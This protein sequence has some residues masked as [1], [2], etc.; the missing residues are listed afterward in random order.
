M[1]IVLSSEGNGF[2]TSNTAYNT[3]MCT[4]MNAEDGLQEP[5]IVK[6]LYKELDVIGIRNVDCVKQQDITNEWI[7]DYVMLYRMDK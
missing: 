1:I 2:R 5:S 7:V 6:D 4:V 3:D